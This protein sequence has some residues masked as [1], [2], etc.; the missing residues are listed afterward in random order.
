MV[1]QVEGEEQVGVR[2]AGRGARDGG[3]RRKEV[4]V[5]P[6]RRSL[7]H[8]A[9]NLILYVAFIGS[10]KAGALHSIR[11]WNGL[12]CRAL[13]WNGLLCRAFRV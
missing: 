1:G 6:K 10:L 5:V 11:E 8:D 2:V 12:L 4:D 7:G 9:S 13:E 3:G